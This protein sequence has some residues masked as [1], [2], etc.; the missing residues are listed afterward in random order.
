MQLL[1]LDHARGIV[2]AALQRAAELKLKPLSVAVLDAGGHLKALERQDGA[3]ILRPQIS[4][5]KAYGALSLG[6]GSRAIYRRA[7]EQAY[8][9][10]SVNTLAGGALIPVPGGVLVRDA[11]GDIIGAVGISGDTSEHDEDCA[12]AGI[13]AAGLAADP[14]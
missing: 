3:S 10:Q 5:A 11:G 12:I 14:G 4:H 7:E 9:V 13:K 6:M 8:F 1:T 2:A